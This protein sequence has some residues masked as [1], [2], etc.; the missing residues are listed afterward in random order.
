MAKSV[1]AIVGRPNVGKSTFFNRC[2]GARHA[3]VDD[4]PGVTR[5]RL[6][7]ETEWAGHEFV[8]VDT[9]GIVV[10]SGDE[11]TSQVYDQARLAVEEADVIVL[12][13]DGK[14]GITGSDLDVAN[15]LR[16]SRKPV[17]VAVNKIDD[18]KDE[19][20]VLEFFQLGLGEP[21]GLSAMRGS[22]G[23]GDLLDIIVAAINEKKGAK[24]GVAAR[25]AGEDGFGSYDEPVRSA[26]DHED[27]EALVDEVKNPLSIAIVGRPNVG[28]SSIVNAMLGASRS[29]VA[30]KPGTTRDAIDTEFRF[31]GRS[32]TLVDTAG[33]RRKSKVDY[34]I[35]AFSVV[36]SLRAISRSDVVVIVV[37]ATQ[38]IADQDQKIAAK[39]EEAGRACVI[40]VNKWDLIA[41]KTSRLMK[42]FTE[43]VHQSLRM[44]NYAEVVF[45]SAQTK[46]RL[47][48]LIEACEKAYSETQKRV[49]TGLLNQIISEAVALVPPPS[50]RRGKRLK[51]YY[52]TQV[53][54]APPTFVLFVNDGK[55]MQQNY[56][57]Y[58]ERK[59]REAFGFAGTPIRVTTRDKK[60]SR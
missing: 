55:L 26:G 40:A 32:I 53:S 19:P 1:V 16:R 54:V 14:Q 6:Y 10:E 52:G 15:V 36:R 43:N 58:L 23:V 13:V 60:E 47:T 39:I 4:A 35:E 28:K 25:K 21:T 3:I 37:D 50:S 33:I 49:G 12:M 8:L 31:R 11:I 22:G 18:P 29:I 44:L 5:D 38:D 7:R 48:K 27:E 57:V 59:I 2:V 45:T 30:S 42:Q 41:D 9:G 51:V 24:R 20:N 56:K 17:I 34:G 46:Q